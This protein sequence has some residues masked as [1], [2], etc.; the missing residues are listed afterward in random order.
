[1][2]GGH[3]THGNLSWRVL[4][5]ERIDKEA[6]QNKFD[7]FALCVFA[8]RMTRIILVTTQWPSKMTTSYAKTIWTSEFWHGIILITH[9][10]ALRVRDD[11][12]CQECGVHGPH[13]S[14]ITLTMPAKSSMKHGRSTA[15]PAM[16]CPLTL[17]RP[18]SPVRGVWNCFT[19]HDARY[20]GFPWVFL[21]DLKDFGGQARSVESWD[22]VICLVECWA[23]SATTWGVDTKMI[24]G[25]SAG[26]WGR[27]SSRYQP[28]L[29]LDHL[30]IWPWTFSSNLPS[31]KAFMEAFRHSKPQGNKPLIPFQSIQIVQPPSGGWCMFMQDPW[32]K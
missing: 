9:Q 24:V 25:F 5:W 21:L 20:K 18:S 23:A 10:A 32:K 11:L 2:L 6:W 13:G 1:M 31:K 4:V 16:R 26:F 27:F 7:A 14:Q 28:I 15:F 3:W 8:I 12:K 17:M 22:V 30:G 29:R 19:F